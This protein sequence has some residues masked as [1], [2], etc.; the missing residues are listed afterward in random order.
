MIEHRNSPRLVEGRF[1]ER[2][3]IAE[4]DRHAGRCVPPIRI[5]AYARGERLRLHDGCGRAFAV[6]FARYGERLAAI[7]QADRRHVEAQRA[8]AAV[9]LGG[10]VSLSQSVCWW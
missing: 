4:F 2:D 5:A 3:V 6:T 1:D 8:V 10:W 7:V 9:V